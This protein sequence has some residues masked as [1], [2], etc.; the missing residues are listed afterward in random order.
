MIKYNF[1]VDLHASTGGMQLIISNNMQI[2]WIV[3][4]DDDDTMMGLV[5]VA[6]NWFFV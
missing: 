2:R 4:D 3:I 1:R 6:A 5:F